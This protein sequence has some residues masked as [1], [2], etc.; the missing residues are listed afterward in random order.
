MGKIATPET[1]ETTYTPKEDQGLRETNVELMDFMAGVES[2]DGG[3]T[4]TNE[5]VR[6]IQLKK[7]LDLD[8]TDLSN[9]KELRKILEWANREGI[10]NRNELISKIREIDY[11]L[12]KPSNKSKLKKIYEWVV[13]DSNIKGLVNKQEAIRN[14]E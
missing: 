14:A 6:L 8:P 13:I 5:A 1:I 9:D 4:L 12:G 10:K 3:I 7:E 11:K 2:E